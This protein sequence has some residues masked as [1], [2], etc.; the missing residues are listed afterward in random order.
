V[1]RGLDIDPEACLAL[2]DSVPGINAA[3]AA[4]ML[5]VA[6]PNGETS[7]MNFEEAAFVYDSLLEVM[8]NL[9]ELLG[10]DSV[11]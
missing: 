8:A 1:W 5:A 7:S 2:E 3:S 11:K 4:G 9:D 10:H 6:V